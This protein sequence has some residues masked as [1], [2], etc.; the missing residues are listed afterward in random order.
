M[1]RLQVPNPLNGE[2]L[3]E[4]LAAQGVAVA[5]DEMAVVGD[6]LEFPLLADAQQPTVAGVVTAHKGSPTTREANRGTLDT[7]MDDALTGLRSY[8]ALSAPTA[9]QTAAAVKLLCQVAIAV[10]RLQRG[11]LDGID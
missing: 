7:R 10:I 11:R 8:V 2:R 1:I 6:R 3:R 9:A 5:W 4:E